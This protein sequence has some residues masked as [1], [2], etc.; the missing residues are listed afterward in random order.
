MPVLPGVLWGG[1]TATS[2]GGGFGPFLDD[3]VTLQET[4][5]IPSELLLGDTGFDACSLGALKDGVQLREM[6]GLVTLWN[7]DRAWG[8]PQLVEAIERAA[9][10][11]RWLIPDADPLVVGD[12]SMERGGYFAG[13]KSHREGLD[14]DIG[15]F[16]G[17]AR[18]TRAFNDLDATTFDVASN[19]ILIRAFLK[20]GL[21]ERILLDHSLIELLRDYLASTGE[22]TAEEI[23]QVFP[24]SAQD[25]WNRDGILHQAIVHH[26]T[27]HRNHLHLRVLCAP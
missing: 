20:T 10:E 12:M 5:D 27:S 18:Q 14:A 4:G 24:R 16:S 11:V 6:E 2:L 21:V 19:W 9:E 22:L 26:A 13:H 23:D 17:H 1:L 8:T 7:A 25:R 15:L 3:D